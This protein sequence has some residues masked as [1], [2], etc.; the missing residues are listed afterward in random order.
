MKKEERQNMLENRAEGHIRGEKQTPLT[1][2][3]V[4]PVP[5]TAASPVGDL[6]VGTS[7]MLLSLREGEVTA[8]RTN[9]MRPIGRS[10]DF[11]SNLD[12]IQY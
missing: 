3:Q 2:P 12:T 4:A 9:G 10:G 5:R 11:R 7:L 1:I 6:F 8:V